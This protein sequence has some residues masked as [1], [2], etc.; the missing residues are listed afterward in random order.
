MSNG[1]GDGH[2]ADHASLADELRQYA[3]GALDL[4]E[5]WVDRIRTQPV[6]ESAPEPAAC[7]VCPV[8]A[9]ITVLRG[10]RS[11]LAVRFAEH[12]AGLLTVLRAA[13]E[14]G[15]GADSGPTGAEPGPPA[16]PRVQRIQVAREDCLTPSARISAD[17]C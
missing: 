12:A 17:P 13:L 6:D 16:P 14:E 5:P 1:H 2:C 8:C 3:G 11:D 7:A 15:V 10:G 4:L 9:L